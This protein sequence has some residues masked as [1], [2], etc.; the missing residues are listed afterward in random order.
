MT[1]MGDQAWEFAVPV[2]VALLF[3][4]QLSLVATIFL[5][6]KLGVF[7]L[8][9]LV[10]GLIDRWSRWRTAVAGIMAQV[11]SVLLIS[12]CLVMLTTQP[13]FAQHEVFG[14]SMNLSELSI[15]LLTGVTAGSVTAAL[16]SGL[17]DIAVGQDWLP[18][19]IHSQDLSRVNAQMKRID[20]FAEVIAPV[21]AGALLS[22]ESQTVPVFGLVVLAVWN[23]FS[24][25]P[26]LTLLRSVFRSSPA[27]SKQSVFVSED[28]I[29]FFLSRLVRGWREFFRQPIALAMIAY[30]CL[31]LSVLSPHGALLT[32]FL[33]GSWQI[34]ETVLGA[35]RGAGALFGLSAT[36][37][38]PRVRA[39][40]GLI[41]ASRIF[42][43]FQSITLIAALI[44]FFLGSVN[45][46]LFLAM[47]LLSR[48]GLYGFS[49]GEGEIR[50]LNIAPGLRGRVNGAATALNSLATLLI[51][52]V[53]SLLP[54]QQLFSVLVLIS[55]ISVVIGAVLFHL[56]AR[57]LDPGIASTPPQQRI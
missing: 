16:G 27:L 19:V 29:R 39:K 21:V 51:F 3:P 12:V 11:L 31:W 30:A 5:A 14:G 47:I 41:N 33:K 37:L 56:W 34:S 4:T 10:A 23:L 48:V 24:F 6:T 38:F 17:M 43:F 9:P 54:S 22:L 46:S 49:L 57:R 8:Q 18:M 35:F 55:V 52:A 26:E 32:S 2:T 28:R 25:V 13:E 50:Q 45:G 44:F 42:I 1:R 40:F 15:L 7:L 36:F 20:L 53:G